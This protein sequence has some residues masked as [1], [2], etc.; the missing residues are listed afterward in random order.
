MIIQIAHFALVWK[1]SKALKSQ[2][3]SNLAN[4]NSILYQLHSASIFQIEV[5]PGMPGG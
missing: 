3:I 4:V 2:T 1:Q 5:W